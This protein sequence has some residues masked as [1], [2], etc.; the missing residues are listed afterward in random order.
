M[1]DLEAQITEW[2]Q[3]MRTAGINAPV[4]LD[5]LEGHLRDDVEQRMGSGSSAPEALAAAIERVGPPGSLKH[6]FEKFGGTK[7]ARLRKYLWSRSLLVAGLFVAGISLC[8]FVVLPLEMRANEQYSAW[9][10][11]DAHQRRYSSP[12]GSACKLMFG[13]GT[14][15]ALPAGLLTL[16]KL[17]VLD[18]QRLVSARRYVLVFNLMLGAL[19]TT[20]EVLTQLMMFIPLQ[21]AYEVGVLHVWY[22][23]RKKTKCA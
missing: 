14:V 12:I 21:L 8:Y 7:E 18:F 10:G 6:E 3:Q 9:M 11:V 17:G 13:F 4:P 22:S 2:R 15:F 19:L 23:Q 5:E 1:F 16:I 20:P